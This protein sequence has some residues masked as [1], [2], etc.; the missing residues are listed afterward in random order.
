[1][2]RKADT[3]MRKGRLLKSIAAGLAALI[4]AMGSAAAEG[5]RYPT[6]RDALRYAQENHPSEMELGTVKYGAKYLWQIRQAMGE[7]GILHFTTTGYGGTL[8]EKS[9]EITVGKNQ[10]IST[11]E[12]E[13]LIRLCPELK[14]IDV[15]E[16]YY[17]GNKGMIALVEAYPDIDF[18]W[19]ITI[20][21]RRRINSDCTAYSSWSGQSQTDKIRSRDLEVLKYV[22]GLKA[23][24]LGHSEITSLDFLQ[25]CPDLELLILGDNQGVTDLTPIGELKHLQYLE[26][27]MVGA[28]DIS[29][30]AGCTELLDL[31]M[32]T[33]YK[34]RDLSPLDGLKKLE[35]FWGNSMKGLSEEEKERFM[36]AHPD[37][38]CMF[39]KTHATAGTWRKHDR[40]DHYIWCLGTGT[41]I[42]FDQPL[43][44]GAGKKSK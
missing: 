8:T 41:W 11:E 10:R 37:T 6:F 5:S 32:S 42:P 21:G 7:D 14:K 36:A 19:K 39:E 35:R 22:P 2:R 31:N 16:H 25:Y 15:T 12:I 13:W 27:F 3:G 43:P 1:M 4:L 38:E 9:T 26:M 24:D 40:Y 30:L 28:E 17:L 23:L 29:P 44:E 18:R 34:I 20:R 33:C